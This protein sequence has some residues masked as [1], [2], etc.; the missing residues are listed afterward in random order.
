MNV[1]ITGK[2]SFFSK[3]LNKSLSNIEIIEIKSLTNTQSKKMKF[4]MSFLKELT[5]ESI[6][7]HAAWNMK[8]RNLNSSQLINLNGTLNLFNSLDEK[9]KTQFIFISS[10]GANKN[11]VSVYGKHKYEVEQRIIKGGGEVLKCGLLIDKD[12][13][14]LDGFFANLYKLAKSVPVIPNFS[15]TNPIYQITND[16]S[17]KRTFETTLIGKGKN[18]IYECFETENYSFKQLVNEVMGINKPIVN[19]PWHVGYYTSKIFEIFKINFPIKS[20]SLLGI[21]EIK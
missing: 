5:P 4:D 10:T 9:T 3:L 14:F 13:P 2:S 19:I 21:K 6:I 7:I 16:Q 15:G 12:N 8:N 17:I 20:D 18:E 11:A 1:F